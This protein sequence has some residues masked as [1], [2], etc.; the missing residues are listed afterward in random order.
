MNIR[1]HIL[2]LA[3]IPLLLWAVCSCKKEATEEAKT[4]A[5]LTEGIYDV[6]G[7][8]DLAAY[9]YG[10]AK[11]L[12]FSGQGTATDIGEAVM[13]LS[14]ISDKT[15]DTNTIYADIDEEGNLLFRDFTIRYEGIR[16]SNKMHTS[17]IRRHGDDT[18]SGKARC[19]M[20]VA[21]F[22]SRDMDF[23]VIAVRHHEAE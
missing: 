23:D 15:G 6:N 2:T 11:S 8:L 14:Y 13:A 17:S 18:I 3:I 19:T 16:C 21:Y 5:R 10:D 20:T 22:L 9:T 12:S 4:Q 1:Q 7:T